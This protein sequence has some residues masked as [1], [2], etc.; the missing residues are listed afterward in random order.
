MTSTSNSEHFT[1]YVAYLTRSNQLTRNFLL[2]EKQI[3]NGFPSHFC[4]FSRCPDIFA[5]LAFWL[6]AAYRILLAG[7]LCV[8]ALPFSPHQALIRKRSSHFPRLILA[9]SSV[10]QRD[11]AGERAGEMER[12]RDILVHQLIRVMHATASAAALLAI[13]FPRTERRCSAHFRH[14]PS[15]FSSSLCLLLP[16]YELLLH[17]P[18]LLPHLQFPRRRGSARGPLVRNCYAFSGSET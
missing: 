11:R 1:L 9:I 2:V 5:P 3:I 6:L 15:I 17:P 14:F 13:I 4:I 16:A 12:I 10:H 18:L 7:S 8:G